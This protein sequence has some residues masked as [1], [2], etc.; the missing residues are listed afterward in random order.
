ML[1]TI[2]V[3]IAGL[4]I[5]T[6]ANAAQA[7]SD[8]KI[9]EQ[10]LACDIPPGQA[11]PVIK[12][13]KALGAKSV[14]AGTFSLP[15]PLL[16]DGLPATQVHVGEEDGVESYIAVF[17]GVELKALAEHAQ[18]KPLAASYVRDTKHGRLSGDVRDR[19]DV[20]LTCTITQ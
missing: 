5:A 2:L 16:V 12:A 19:T 8:I 15:G 7:S 4:S 3:A 10:A 11:K 18:L 1:K 6:C 17:H 14:G 20:W 9:L 13:L